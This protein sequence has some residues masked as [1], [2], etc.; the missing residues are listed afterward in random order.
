MCYNNPQ[1]LLSHLEL[2]GGS[3]LAG[4][5][6]VKD[7]FTQIA[8]VLNK[9]G[10]LNNDKA[11]KFLIIYSYTDLDD[12]IHESMKKKRHYKT[13][14]DKEV[15]DINLIFVLS[16]YKVVIEI[17]NNYQLD[18]TNKTFGKLIDFEPKLITATEYA[19]NLLNITNSKD[20]I[21]VHCDAIT[22]SLVHGQ[23]TNTIAVIPTDNL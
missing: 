15:Y 8:D 7:E 22:D 6:G 2:L 20:T 1:H 12:Y 14:N 18:F 16:T 10:I 23:S 11:I 3:I 21:N 4:N 17:S 5:D 19:K 9:I 13:F